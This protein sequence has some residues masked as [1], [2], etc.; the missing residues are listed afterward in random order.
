MTGSVGSLKLYLRVSTKSLLRY[1]IL[2]CKHCS[3]RPR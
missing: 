2:N 3:R 1:R